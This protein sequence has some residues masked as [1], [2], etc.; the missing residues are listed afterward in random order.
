MKRTIGLALL[1]YEELYTLL[2]RIEAILNSRPLTPLSNDPNDLEPLTP[3]HFLAGES[4]TAVFEDDITEVSTNRLSRWQRV[5]Q[6]RQNFWRRWNREYILG[7]Q[8]RSKWTRPCNT[9]TVGSLV[10]IVEDDV[11]PLQW[12]LARITELHYG[13]DGLPRVASLKTKSGV[14][15][16]SFHKLCRLPIS[17]EDTKIVLTNYE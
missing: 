8:G 15:K 17:T 9:P 11:H 1:T 13:K 5:E 7:L 4:L 12:N 14:K 2:T 10:L 16:R 3:G 6:L